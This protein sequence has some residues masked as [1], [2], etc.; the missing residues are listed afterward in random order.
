[1]ECCALKVSSSLAA[2]C[3]TDAGIEVLSLR[4][5]LFFFFFKQGRMNSHVIADQSK[6]MRTFLGMV[7][8]TIQYER[9]VINNS[10][11]CNDVIL[12]S[13]DREGMNCGIK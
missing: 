11:D 3:E 9:S 8:I 10:E 4:F 13:K 5:F 2:A 7:M 1:M 12:S 6:V